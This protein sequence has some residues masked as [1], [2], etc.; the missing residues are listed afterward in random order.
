MESQLEQAELVSIF[1]NL[2][3]RK[4]DGNRSNIKGNIM[5]NSELMKNGNNN[6]I[7]NENNNENKIWNENECIISDLNPIFEIRIIDE[8]RLNFYDVHHCKLNLSYINTKIMSIL[9]SLE[10]SENNDFKSYE[11]NEKD[12]DTIDEQKN[13]ITID[14]DS[15]KLHEIENKKKYERIKE[16]KHEKEKENEN[17]KKDRIAV[18]FCLDQLNNL[19]NSCICASDLIILSLSR[20]QRNSRYT[21]V[22]T[23][24]NNLNVHRKESQISYDLV[25]KIFE[26]KE[27]DVNKSID[28]NDDNENVNNNN[29]N[30]NNN[31]N[32][33]YNDNNNYNNYNYNNDDKENINNNNNNNDIN[34]NNNNDYKSTN[35]SGTFSDL[36]LL[37]KEIKK[38]EKLCLKA[39]RILNIKLEKQNNETV[40]HNKQMRAEK[41]TNYKQQ[42]EIV[43]NVKVEENKNKKKQKAQELEERGE[44]IIYNDQLIIDIDDNQDNYENYDFNILYSPATEEIMMK[45]KKQWLDKLK[46]IK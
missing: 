37:I 15:N 17:E 25:S 35:P 42:K 38:V 36:I 13:L 45:E 32:Y 11:D 18:Q 34:N 39:L 33:Y 28:K 46:I 44:N 27:F 40:D 4:I 16:K 2:E 24:S 29:Y 23:K 26:K 1:S 19:K 12:N 14:T 31:N 5:N 20:T 21:L 41:K 10:K 6:Q 43:K 8:I 7:N 30:D 9:K 22:S 3:S